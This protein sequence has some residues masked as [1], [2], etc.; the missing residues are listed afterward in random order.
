M[1]HLYFLLLLCGYLTTLSWLQSPQ[2]FCHATNVT[3]VSS[4]NNELLNEFRAYYSQFNT[5]LARLHTQQMDLLVTQQLNQD[6]NEFSTLVD[7]VR[8]DAPYSLQVYFSYS[9]S[10]IEMFSQMSRNGNC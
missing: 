9:C 8:S 7:S 6:L 2:L 1:R 4:E 5:L 3:A 10:S